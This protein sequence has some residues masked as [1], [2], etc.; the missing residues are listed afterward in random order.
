[1][2]QTPGFENRYLR[3]EPSI[4]A[5]EQRKLAAKTVCVCG[6]GGIGGYVV[7]ALARLGIGRI[8]AIDPDCF[9]ATNLN[10]QLFSNEGNLGQA[11]AVAARQRIAQIN[12]QVDV[13]AACEAITEANAGELLSGCDVVIDALDS[14]ETRLDLERWCTQAGKPLVHGAISGWNA[15]VTAIAPESKSL[16]KIYPSS[17]APDT[18][19]V[20]CAPGSPAF[21]PMLAASL[22]VT[23]CVKVLLGKGDALYGKLLVIDLLRSSWRIIDL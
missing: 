10:R 12:S 14:A 23:E 17:T 8:I 19:E 6:C 20:D 15:Q 9:E 16:S 5:N 13:V 7:E 18:G 3:N 22:E 4:S 21:T 2:S 11:K 1:M